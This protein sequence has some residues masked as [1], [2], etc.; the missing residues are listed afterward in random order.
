MESHTI[1]HPAAPVQAEP[2]T[3][4]YGYLS[5]EETAAWLRM[6][7]KTLRNQISAIRTGRMPASELPRWVE[8]AGKPVFPDMLRRAWWLERCGLMPEASLIPAPPPAPPRAKRGRPR[9]THA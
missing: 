2:T 9:K 8:L 3:T 1:A 6:Q 4:L 5:V 7:P